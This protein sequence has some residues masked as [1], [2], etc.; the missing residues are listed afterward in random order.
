VARNAD[1]TPD[2]NYRIYSMTKPLT[3]VAIVML[4]QEG[5]F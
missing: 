5:L 1:A 3:A 4:Y 2:T